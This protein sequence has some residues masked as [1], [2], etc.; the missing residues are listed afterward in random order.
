MFG[1]KERPTFF[2]DNSSG[3]GGTPYDASGNIVD[4]SKSD[5]AAVSYYDQG[6]GY[7][8]GDATWCYKT[9]YYQKI[10]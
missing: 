8:K 5:H 6:V 10:L 4:L 2:Y 1:R 9:M 7:T 3:N